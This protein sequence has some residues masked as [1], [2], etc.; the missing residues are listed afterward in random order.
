MR[1]ALDR[2]R[3]DREVACALCPLLEPLRAYDQARSTDLGLTLRTYVETGGSIAA[4][5]ERLFVHRNSVVYRIQR[6]Q[7][8]AELDLRDPELFATLSLALAL[9]SP[10]EESEEYSS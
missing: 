9:T 7:E 5:A 8:V 6:I 10:G 4:T 1:Q 3:N 2:L